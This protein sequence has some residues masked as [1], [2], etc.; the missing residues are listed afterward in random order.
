MKFIDNYELHLQIEKI[1]KKDIIVLKRFCQEWRSFIKEN[2]I[3]EVEKI[4]CK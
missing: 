3:V 4:Q 1:N 2:P